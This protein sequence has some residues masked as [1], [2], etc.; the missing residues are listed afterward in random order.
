VLLVI[1][2]VVT[3]L[4]VMFARDVSRSAHEATSPRR[5]ENRSFAQLAN[6]LVTYENNA[7]F[8]LAFLLGHGQGLSRPVFAAR[9]AQIDQQLAP[10]LSDSALLRRPVLAHH[11]QREIITL[12]QQRVASDQAIIAAT[13][14]SLSLPGASAST[15]T[16][17]SAQ[18]ALAA[19]VSRWNYKRFSL[20]DEPGRVSL[21]AATS[22]L[23]N[24]TLARAL[25]VLTTSPSLTLTRAVSISAVAVT[26]SPL[27]APAGDVVLPPVTS[28]HV[29]VA[30]TNAAYCTQPVTV[31]VSL[32]SSSGATER[33]VM[34]AIIGPDASFA[35]DATSLTTY[36]SEKA[37]L[38]VA[39][40]GAPASAKGTLVKFYAMTLAPSGAG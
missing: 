32:I 24:L 3:V 39:V 31:T 12:T 4:V 30:V 18:T 8:H 27:P 5:S 33:S 35:F 28:I 25:S 6:R 11:V 19:A 2:L 23:A 16:P 13:M 15:A 7:D 10:L 37:T 29:G 17:A 40:S 21:T 38:R 22:P 26:P 1:A 20:V 34:H 14:T 9:L 36:P